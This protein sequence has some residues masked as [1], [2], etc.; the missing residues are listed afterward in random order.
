[1]SRAKNDILT[2]AIITSC[3]NSIMAYVEGYIM[4]Y[5]MAYVEYFGICRG[6]KMTY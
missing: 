3:N 5:I 2:C 4:G 1:M 6:P